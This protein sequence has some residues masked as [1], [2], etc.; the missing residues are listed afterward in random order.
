[1]V[2]A[3]T[4]GVLM[5]AVSVTV[6]AIYYMFTLRLTQTNMKNTLATRKLQFLSN[7]YS[8]MFGEEGY[9]RFGEVMNM[10]WRD[11]DDF[12]RKYGSD[13][14]IDAYVK[15]ATLWTHFDEM[16]MIVKEG[17]IDIDT[18]YGMNSFGLA[19]AWVKFRDVIR[20]QRLRYNGANM[21]ENWEWVAEELIRIKR[22]REPGYRLPENF[23]KYI[24]ASNVSTQ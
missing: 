23:L 7:V 20:E 17:I 4:I 21:Y 13:Y 15:R 12:E 14:N 6:A 1:M 16:G 3:Q 9:R 5:T 24:P 10:Q 11:Y 2:D 18:V 19:L 22:E 8:Q